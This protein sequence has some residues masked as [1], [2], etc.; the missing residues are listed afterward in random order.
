LLFFLYSPNLGTA[1]H[2]G[3]WLG[4]MVWWFGTGPGSRGRKLK[5][6]GR[7]VEKDLKRFKVLEGG[8]NQDNKGDW[9]N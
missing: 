6:K 3:S 8:Q 2:L 7:K 4:L 9:V 5:A 1:Q